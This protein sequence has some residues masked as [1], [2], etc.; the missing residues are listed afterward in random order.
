MDLLV[1]N[2]VFSTLT[3]IRDNKIR[4]SVL[5]K[6]LPLWRLIIWGL[7]VFVLVV[8]AAVVRLDVQRLQMDFDR[9]DRLRR[10]A[11]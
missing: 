8:I 4:T 7:A 6:I 1:Q 9:N 2:G 11:E 10:A 3:Q 5:A